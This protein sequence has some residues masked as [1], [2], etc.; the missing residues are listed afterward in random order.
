M[1]EPWA[2][3]RS[4]G[5]A[6]DDWAASEPV[7]EN[8]SGFVAVAKSTRPSRWIE[9]A[10]PPGTGLGTL[11]FPA[12]AMPRLS[13]RIVALARSRPLNR[14]SPSPLIHAAPPIFPRSTWS[15]DPFNGDGSPLAWAVNRKSPACTWRRMP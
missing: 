13:R 8:P 6:L 2:R 10:T 14:S 9:S 3:A 5:S 15:E 4:D 11:M 12:A 7:S 1:N